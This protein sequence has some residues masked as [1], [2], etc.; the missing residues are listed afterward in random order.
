MYMY[1]SISDLY[2]DTEQC[3]IYPNENLIYDKLN[4]SQV[5]TLKFK[6]E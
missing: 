1:R 5:I 6:N 4:L 2:C 3:T